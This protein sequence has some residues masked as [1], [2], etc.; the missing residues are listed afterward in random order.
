MKSLH[1]LL[2]PL[3]I[4][5][6]SFA[7][8]PEK[9]SYQA[10]LRDGEGIL[11]TNKELSVN[12]SVL[13]GNESGIEV[14]TETHFTE[15]NANG[16]VSLE[17]GSGQADG[18]VFS[19]IDWEDGP[20]FIK[21]ETTVDGSTLT[22]ISELLSVPYALHAKDASKVNGLTVATEVPESAV[23]TDNQS[24]KEVTIDEIPNLDADDVQQALENL[25]GTIADAGDMKQTAYDSNN[26]SIV[27]NASKVNGLTV[28]TN[29]P[30]DAL[31][32]DSQKGNE[33]DLVTALDVDGDGEPE[34]T[35]EAALIELNKLLKDLQDEVK[36]S[37]DGRL[38]S[39][40]TEALA[41]G[42]ILASTTEASAGT[43]RPCL[44]E[45]EGQHYFGGIQESRFGSVCAYNHKDKP[46]YKT[47]YK[48]LDKD[49]LSKTKNADQTVLTY[50]ASDGSE[51]KLCVDQK[52]RYGYEKTS[53]EPKRCLFAVPFS[54]KYGSVTLTEGSSLNYEYLK[55]NTIRFIDDSDS[56]KEGQR[57][58]RTVK[59]DRTYCAASDTEGIS[60]EGQ[61]HSDKGTCH[62]NG[63]ELQT[64]FYV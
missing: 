58:Y 5:F 45:H 24:A 42:S 8:T 11:V 62:V 13:Q 7:Q 60:F 44:V 48:T 12:L 41:G 19:S 31:F 57:Y 40:T 64:G 61:Y 34:T 37:T 29:V 1:H 10:I 2:F 59:D 4:T 43:H 22:S 17:I 49:F 20:Y 33:V 50:S 6:I 16:L 55:L 27:D 36:L 28:G 54:N 56:G 26:D 30:V 18:S 21:T 35:V 25:H 32:T 51:N 38:L 15:T 23:F 47:S 39:A 53:E 46:Y 14:Y 52:G 9:V 3:F 63:K